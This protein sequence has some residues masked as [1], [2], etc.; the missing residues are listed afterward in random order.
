MNQVLEAPPP[1]ACV[2]FNSFV[3]E[4]RKNFGAVDKEH[5][6]VAKLVTIALH[7]F[8]SVAEFATQFQRHATAKNTTMQHY[9]E[10]STLAFLPS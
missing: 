5:N 6:A 8:S 9:V 4:I 7:E 3:I 2:N 1:P 10:C